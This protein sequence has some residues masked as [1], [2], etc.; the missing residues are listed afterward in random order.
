MVTDLSAEVALGKGCGR[1]KEKRVSRT[2]GLFS[3]PRRRRISRRR[4]RPEEVG[5]GGGRRCLGAGGSR[6]R[7]TSRG[8][9]GANN[10]GN[11]RLF[12]LC[13][14]SFCC[15]T[16]TISGRVVDSAIH[17]VLL[18]HEYTQSNFSNLYFLEAQAEQVDCTYTFQNITLL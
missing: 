18:A 16:S 3:A 11:I 8:P 1:R 10:F 13:L 5:G 17:S 12:A 6:P 7:V 15:S 4:R 2:G 14:V 9:S